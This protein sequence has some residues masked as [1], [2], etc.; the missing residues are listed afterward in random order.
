MGDQ[1][2]P[3]PFPWEPQP[4]E[5]AGTY[6]FDGRFVATATVINDLGNDVV[7]ALYFIAQRLVQED[8]GIDYILAF[9]HRETGKVVWM[10]D[11]LNDDMKTSESKEWVEEYN[12]CTLCY[13]SE[14]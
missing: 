13:P 8:D 9:K 14:R 6:R 11:Q 4:Q 3:T 5:V 1:T 2:P 12:T 10:I 7:R